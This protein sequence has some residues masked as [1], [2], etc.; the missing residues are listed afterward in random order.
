M[1]RSG[2]TLVEMAIV[3]VILGLL[4][5]GI[6]AGQALIRASELRAV[7]TEFQQYASAA[8][9]FRDKYIML[10]G[11]MNNATTYWGKADPT[12]STCRRT[13]TNDTTTCD[14]DGDG[15]MGSNNAIANENF[16]F[17]KQL[18]NAGLIKGSYTGSGAPVASYLTPSPLNAPTSKVGNNALWTVFH[19]VGGYI[20]G[21]AY[22]QGPDYG[23][24]LM[25]TREFGGGAN[26]QI[27]LALLPPEE[28]WTI[29]SK[30]DDGIPGTGKILSNY[31][32][33]T[34]GGVSNSDVANARY[35]L[36]ARDVRCML[37]FPQAFTF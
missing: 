3:L 26:N 9:T 12:P 10:P 30:T 7:T 23:N 28:A 18:A 15:R 13:P 29:D 35:L 4:A 31:T 6:L 21:A 34:T 11:D 33:C 19:P 32:N 27:G 14:G 37:F 16:A 24:F 17:W 8:N 2:F 25:L 20:T 1:Q 5:G 36:T 22:F